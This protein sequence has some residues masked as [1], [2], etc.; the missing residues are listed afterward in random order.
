MPN[1][2][3]TLDHLRDQAPDLFNMG[4]SFERLMTTA[5][6]REPGILGDHFSKVWL[7]NDW[8]DRDGGDTGIDLVA[9]EEEGLCAIHCKFFDPHN[10]VPKNGI[11]SFMSASEPEHFTLRLMRQSGFEWSNE[12]TCRPNWPRMNDA[13]ISM[14]G[15]IHSGQWSGKRLAPYQEIHNVDD[16]VA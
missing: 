9:E 5:L 6:E 16:L 11:D 10:P 8:P 4:H 12:N 7:W 14:G 15:P 2:D 13:H 1:F 3:K